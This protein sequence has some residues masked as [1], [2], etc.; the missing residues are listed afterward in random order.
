MGEGELS[1]VPLGFEWMG[2][3]ITDCFTRTFFLKQQQPSENWGGKA[4]FC[5]HFFLTCFHGNKCWLGKAISLKDLKYMHSSSESKTSVSS[6]NSHYLQISQVRKQEGRKL[7]GSVCSNPLALLFPSTGC[8][9]GSGK[10][11]CTKSANWRELFHIPTKIKF[12]RKGGEKHTQ[13]P[14]MVSLYPI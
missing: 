7:T 3:S 13:N 12:A 5:A 14:S 4:K 2:I 6:V 11:A 1:T 9:P 10:N 8:Q